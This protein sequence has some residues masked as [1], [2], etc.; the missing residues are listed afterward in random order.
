[1]LMNDLI[2]STVNQFSKYGSPLFPI[3][4][5]RI[6]LAYLSTWVY[7]VLQQFE[8]TVTKTGNC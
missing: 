1:M 4:N 3:Y 2:N 6:G 7:C 5:P 8:P